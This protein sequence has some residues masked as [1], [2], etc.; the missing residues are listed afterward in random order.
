MESYK[1]IGVDMMLKAIED[2][3]N[4]EGIPLPAVIWYLVRGTN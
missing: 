3:K 1:A 4:I 2:G